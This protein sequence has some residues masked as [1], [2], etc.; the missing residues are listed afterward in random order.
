MCALAVGL[1]RH[2]HFDRD[3]HRLQSAAIRAHRQSRVHRGEALGVWGRV[4]RLVGRQRPPAR[5]LALGGRDLGRAGNQHE[6][7]GGRDYWQ[8][9]AQAWSTA[10]I[11]GLAHADIE[12]SKDSVQIDG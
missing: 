7:G 10:G 3:V 1:R 9:E 5:Q 11:A 2:L 8:R 4:D 6:V 12:R